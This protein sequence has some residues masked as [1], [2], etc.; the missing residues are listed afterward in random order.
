MIYKKIR[1][2]NEQS[3]KHRPYLLFVIYVQL[4]IEFDDNRSVILYTV[5]IKFNHIVCYLFKLKCVINFGL[6]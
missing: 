2:V 1:S 4:L 5:I 3:P 6:R